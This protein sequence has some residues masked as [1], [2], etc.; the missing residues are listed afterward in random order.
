MLE[1]FLH[2]LSFDV[3]LHQFFYDCQIV[4]SIFNYFAPIAVCPYFLI[5]TQFIF[6]PALWRRPDKPDFRSKLP[7]LHA[8]KSQLC[9]PKYQGFILSAKILTPPNLRGHLPTILQNHHFI[10]ALITL[11]KKYFRVKISFIKNLLSFSVHICL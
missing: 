2:F 9:K 5:Q 3:I 1:T 11:K 8:Y 4:S 7:R 10:K 6:L